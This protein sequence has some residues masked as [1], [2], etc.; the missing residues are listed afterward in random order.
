MRAVPAFFGAVLGGFL[1][2][3]LSACDQESTPLSESLTNVV[4]IKFCVFE[5]VKGQPGTLS[6]LST[7]TNPDAIRGILSRVDVGH[8]RPLTKAIFRRFVIFQHKGG[9]VQ[10]SYFEPYYDRAGIRND[11]VRIGAKEFDA[12]S[13]T[14]GYLNSY[15]AA[16]Y[17]NAIQHTD[18]SK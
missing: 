2:A 5:T 8:E 14:I 4:A 10:L 13:E 1:L 16:F 18:S 15:Y 17:T 7:V 3:T 12:T 9:E 6:T 11:T